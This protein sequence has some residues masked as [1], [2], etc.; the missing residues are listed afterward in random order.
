MH[1]CTLLS[2]LES[3]DTSNAEMRENVLVCHQY[4]LRVNKNVKIH[5]P[6]RKCFK[7]RNNE[8]EEC[9]LSHA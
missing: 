3:L 5:G 9:G 2:L 6:G 8:R 7:K 4:V 1:T